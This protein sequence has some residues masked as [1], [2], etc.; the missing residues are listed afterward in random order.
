MKIIICD[1]GNAACAIVTASNGYTMMIDCGCHADKTNPVETFN[2]NKKWLGARDYISK[3]SISYPIALLHITHPDDDHIRNAIRIK[4]EL[5]PYLLHKN[6]YEFFSDS[7]KIN[8]DYIKE[9]DKPYRGDNPEYI[10]W[11]FNVNITTK[12]P[13]S[14]CKT[15]INLRDKE[16]NNSS[17]LR[18]IKEG[19]LGILFCGDLEK[20]GWDYLI[21]HEQNFVNALKSNGVN[22]LIAPHHGHKSGFP[23]ALFDTIGNIDVAILS[24]DS[25]A[26][27][28]GTDVSTQYSSHSNGYKYKSINDG[29]SYYG[30]VLTTRSNG[31]IYIASNSDT[32][33]DCMKIWTDKAS[34]NHEIAY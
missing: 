5:T 27:K 16:R 14:I 34:P 20:N 23:S 28:E 17:I 24:K 21:Q 32:E 22:I 26:N 30:K 29:H 11:G 6:E 33:H 2:A 7:N 25:E 8:Q 18:Y 3:R 13:V 1:V 19:N 10:N 12:I 15:N 9:L 31:N 4:K